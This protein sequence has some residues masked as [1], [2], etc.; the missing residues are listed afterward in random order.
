M[1]RSTPLAVIAA[2]LLLIVKPVTGHVD[3]NDPQHHDEAPD[4]AEPDAVFATGSTGPIA[5]DGPHEFIVSANLNHTAVIRLQELVKSTMEMGG[6]PNATLAIAKDDRLVYFGTMNNPAIEQPRTNV[7]P[8]IRGRIASL[9]KAITAAA[10]LKL[11]QAGELSLDTRAFGLLPDA[12][13]PFIPEPE[14]PVDEEDDRLDLITVTHLLNHTAG[15]PRE[16]N[17]IVRGDIQRSFP[18][19]GSTNRMSVINYFRRYSHL[20][21]EPGTRFLYSNVGYLV[22]GQVVQSASD[23]LSYEEYVKNQL[24]MPLG[25]ERMEIANTVP[26]HSPQFEYHGPDVSDLRMELRDASGGWIASAPDLL[27]FLIATQP[28]GDLHSL[29]SA[30]PCQPKPG[31]EVCYKAGFNIKGNRKWHNGS[32][33]G[34]AAYMEANSTDNFSWTIIF[35]ARQTGW[36]WRQLVDP[37]NI[38]I[39]EIQWPN[40]DLFDLVD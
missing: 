7:L 19:D 16:S 30:V 33:P 17:Y 25:I 26:T 34:T 21:T 3:P 9:S 6:I 1:F 38:A 13:P 14:E 8:P 40:E 29:Y 24:L 35:N 2:A 5:I 11:V 39:R 32:N 20:A 12:E 4:F 18:Y 27:R 31:S 36:E 22:L 23:E 28:D 37:L 10:A 15:F